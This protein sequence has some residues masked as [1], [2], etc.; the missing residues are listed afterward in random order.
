MYGKWIETHSSCVELYTLQFVHVDPV[1]S[2]AM[3]HCNQTWSNLRWLNLLFA[4][5]VW[6]RSYRSTDK[7]RQP[8][9]MYHQ[10]CPPFRANLF[11]FS[12]SDQKFSSVILIVYEEGKC[13]QTESVLWHSWVCVV[14]FS[15]YISLNFHS[16]AIRYPHRVCWSLKSCTRSS[17]RTY[18]CLGLTCVRIMWKHRCI[19]QENLKIDTKSVMVLCVC[20]TLVN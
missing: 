4:A 13:S 16:G 8:M 9:T 10:K 11:S 2:Y 7:F 1:F 6:I 14:Y 12:K 18:R 20:V 3:L 17:L 19:P 15:V 5:S